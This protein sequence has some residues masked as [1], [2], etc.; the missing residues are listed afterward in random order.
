MSRELC[1]EIL[2]DDGVQKLISSRQKTLDFIATRA[3][4]YAV[5][6]DEVTSEIED[7]QIVS[8]A[9]RGLPAAFVRNLRKSFSGQEIAE[10][11]VTNAI[12]LMDAVSVADAAVEA[13]AAEKSAAE[14]AR[15]AEEVAEAKAAKEA[16]E[17]ARVAEQARI[18][19]AQ[20]TR[21]IARKEEAERVAKEAAE[22]AAKAAERKQALEAEQAR[23]DAEKASQSPSGADEPNTLTAAELEV[24]PLEQS[25]LPNG[26]VS[27]LA[28]IKLSTIGQV[29]KLIESEGGDLTF[30]D[31]IGPKSNVAIN[32]RIDELKAKVSV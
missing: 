25:G 30:I 31:G 4:V 27:D 1:L 16:E 24:M 15:L 12:A 10:N 26:I 32:E 8:L 18:R 14:T 13:E 19:E 21:E 20:E 11:L 28:K 17:A 7:D 23:I 9:R 5:G 2:I 29:I 22:L 6:F 3:M